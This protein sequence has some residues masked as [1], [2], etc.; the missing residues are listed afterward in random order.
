AHVNIGIPIKTHYQIFMHMG[1]SPYVNTCIYHIRFLRMI[2]GF[3][4]DTPILGYLKDRPKTQPIYMCMHGFTGMAIYGIPITLLNNGI[5]F[6]TI[7]QPKIRQRK[8]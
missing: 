3:R 5:T 8:I 1:K 7:W 2:S 4:Y 6:L